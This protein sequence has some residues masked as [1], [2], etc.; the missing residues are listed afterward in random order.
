MRSARLLLSKACG[1]HSLSLSFSLCSLRRWALR[2]RGGHP[3][4]LQ[5]V[6]QFAAITDRPAIYAA[7]N[8]R[9]RDFAPARLATSEVGQRAHSVRASLTAAVKHVVRP[10]RTARHCTNEWA[11]PNPRD[12]IITERVKCGSFPCGQ[13]KINSRHLM[14]PRWAVR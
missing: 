10:E 12:V 14:I 8:C 11:I 4:P 7:H 2:H 5:L 13:K 3:S 6:L 9:I 1:T